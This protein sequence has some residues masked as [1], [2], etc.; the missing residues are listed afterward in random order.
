M[1]YK[2]VH[3]INRK[4]KV[5]P[6]EIIEKPPSAELKSNQKDQ[7]TLPSYDVLDQTLHCYVDESYSLEREEEWLLP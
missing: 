7:D 1:V 5:I 3:Y 6:K 4:S 2:L